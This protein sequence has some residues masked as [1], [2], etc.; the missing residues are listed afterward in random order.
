MKLRVIVGLIHSR[1]NFAAREIERGTR[2]GC[3]GKNGRKA[4]FKRAW[5]LGLLGLGTLSL[6]MLGAC[7]GGVS[8]GSSSDPA[9]GTPLSVSPATADLFADVPATFSV[10]GGK[11]PYSQFSSNN[12]ALSLT[13][14]TAST[15]TAIANAV[16]SETPVD[17]TVR[18]AANTSATVKATIKPASLNNQITFTPFAPTATGCGTNAICS[19]G[20]A[21]VV[22]KA[23]QNGV[24]LRNRPVRFDVFQGSFQLV[25][26]GTNV[27]VNTLTINT[28]DQGEAVARLRVGAGVPTQVATL[29][30]ADVIS[31]LARRYNFSIVQ[32][33]DGKGILSTLP[34]AGIVIK[35][36]KGAAGQ[37]GNCP[38]GLNARVD[39]Y[40]FGGTPP[41][42]VASPLPG[43][44]A[45]NTS[46]VS[47][48]GGSFT[49]Q[50]NNCGKVGFIVSDATG[51]SVETAQIDA[52]QGDKGDA[53]T[54]T[55]A[56][57]V[58][59]TEFSLA[60]GTTQSVSL[61]GTGT[62]AA[63]VVN[64]ASNPGLSVN[65]T[66]AAL[67][68]TSTLTAG[69]GAI[70]SSPVNINFVQQGSQTSVLVKVTVTGLVAGSC[71]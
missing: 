22:V 34:S 12:V 65:P 52:Q 58:T 35:G 61:T 42:A 14:T 17:I 21:Q 24:V 71:Q 10:L 70:A 25:T 20:D 16:T 4:V 67:P 27:L 18:D 15:F 53:A 48:N 57:A 49:A 45:P 33:V 3:N 39:F 62:F 43:V 5:H 31:G 47:S 30:T 55:P 11:A 8:S 40:I 32:Q 9:T 23:A 7:G 46:V 63:S 26:P 56:F 29:Q 66:A 44:A 1:N 28:D 6:A 60:C 36:S 50:V 51:R 13:A 41:Y 19:G 38:S 64:A 2:F 37:D 68:G 59:P 54:V 69:K